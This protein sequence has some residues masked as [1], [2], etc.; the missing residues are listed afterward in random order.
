MS[1]YLSFGNK[2]DL[3]HFVKVAKNHIVRVVESGLESAQEG[4]HHVRVL[5]ILPGVG[6]D[7]SLAADC[8]LILWDAEV[9][10]EPVEEGLE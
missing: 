1:P 5:A 2:R 3:L 8:C 10:A 9:A 7:T 6:L 4:N